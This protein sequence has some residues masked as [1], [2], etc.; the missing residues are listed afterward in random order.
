M[1]LD[2]LA[3]AH[4]YRGLPA[5][6]VAALDFLRATDLASLPLGKTVIDGE[7]LFALTQEYQPKAA[8]VLKY[9]SHR[10]YW[11]VQ[12]VVHGVERMGWNTLARMTESEPYIAEKDVAFFT[13][14]GD[15]FYV[16]AGTFTIFGPHDVHMPGVAVE[17]TGPESPLVRKVVVKVEV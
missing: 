14:S 16:P 8:N 6:L 10:R 9:E 15:L 5:R 13:G 4:L 1:I 2:L 3:N 11:D 17:G 7:R 12:Y